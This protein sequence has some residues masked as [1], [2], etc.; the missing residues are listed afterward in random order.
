MM[1]AIALALAPESIQCS[2]A[3]AAR[4]SVPPAVMLAVAE[5]EGGAANQW[6]A[7]NN[8][9]LDVGPMQFNTA[10]LQTLSQY[11]ITAGSVAAG[12]CYPFYLAAWRLQRHLALDR[13]DLWRRAANYNSRTPRYNARYRL[14]LITKAS[15]W[16]MWLISCANVSCLTFPALPKP[17]NTAG[18]PPAAPTMVRTSSY[19]PRQI[20]VST[21]R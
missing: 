8:G 5:A 10:Y 11:G 2:V 7:N 3:A 19:I 1:A 9:T 13:G 14:V 4:Y 6:R 15:R 20:S 18:T 17:V 12:G 21:P 16:H